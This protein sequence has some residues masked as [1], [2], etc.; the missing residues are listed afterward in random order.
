MKITI[1]FTLQKY[2][3][4]EK[5]EYVLDV[6]NI[7]GLETNF[8][9]KP[10]ISNFTKLIGYLKKLN[11]CEEKII[12][13]TDSNLYYK[14]DLPREYSSL[15]K[16]KKIIPVPAGIKGD[17]AIISYCLRNPNSLI[18]SNDL[19][20]EYYQYLPINWIINK[21]VT[22][23]L[24][25]GEFYLIPMSDQ[26]F[27]NQKSCY[28]SFENLENLYWKFSLILLGCVINQPF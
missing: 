6:P 18:I 17:V 5:L 23:L 3:N 27:K 21:G 11:I 10:K 19:F 24:V 12:S 2:P 20:R 28:A 25:K 26:K 8:N 9:S 1:Y 22:V 7:C 15:V 14:I 4:Y 13:Y 16:D